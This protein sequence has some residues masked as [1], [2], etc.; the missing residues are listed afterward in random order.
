[1]EDKLRRRRWMRVADAADRLQDELAAVHPQ[2]R[3]FRQTGVAERGHRCVAANAAARESVYVV[4]WR[5]LARGDHEQ[6]ARPAAHASSC[7]RPP[8]VHDARYV[9]RPCATSRRPSDAR[10][11]RDGVSVI[12]WQPRDGR[13]PLTARLDRTGELRVGPA[14][15]SAAGGA[16]AS[17]RRAPSATEGRRRRA[18]FSCSI[19]STIGARR[20]PGCA[21]NPGTSASR[22][23]AAPG[24]RSRPS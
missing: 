5:C 8:P 3:A 1:M 22:C 15:R 14:G 23:R 11:T 10:R 21:L 9:R 13:A 4:Q 20:S 24:N 6:P 19:S 18:R 16:R 7:D 12:A 17:H 2:S